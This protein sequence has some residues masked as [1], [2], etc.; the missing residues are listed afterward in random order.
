[1][2]FKEFRTMLLGS[3]IHIHT[4]H[5][6]LTFANLNTQRVLWWRCYLKELSP[7]MHYIKGHNNI[8]VYA[9]SWLDRI[10]ES[11]C[12]EG[13]NATLEMPQEL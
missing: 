11:Q 12:L 5:K 13:R 9:F 7:T 3:E 10:D 1:M 2:V 8:I 4:D 6:K